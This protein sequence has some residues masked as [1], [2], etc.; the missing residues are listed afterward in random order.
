VAT[1]LAEG[2]I[3]APYGMKAWIDLCSGRGQSH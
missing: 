1:G 3:D 2:R